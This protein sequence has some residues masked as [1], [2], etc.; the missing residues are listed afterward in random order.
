MFEGTTDCFLMLHFIFAWV[1]L[2]C[3]QLQHTGLD[4]FLQD[5]RTEESSRMD[6]VSSCKISQK[7]DSVHQNFHRKC[8]HA[9]GRKKQ[10]RT[11]ADLT[12]GGR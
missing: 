5:N 2:K 8:G 7:D 11:E 4:Y 1:Y 9:C 6:C 12:G 10:T 3:S